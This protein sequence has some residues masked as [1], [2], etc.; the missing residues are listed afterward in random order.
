MFLSYINQFE[1]YDWF[2]RGIVRQINTKC[3][4]SNFTYATVVIVEFPDCPVQCKGLPTFYFPI[5]S[6]IWRFTSDLFNKNGIK[7]KQRIT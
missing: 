2:E 5:E 6:I 1:N 3:C 4:P 7:I